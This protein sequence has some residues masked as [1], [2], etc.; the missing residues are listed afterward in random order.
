M[1][2]YLEFVTPEL[3]R[4]SLAPILADIRSSMLEEVDFSKEA[5][6]LTSFGEFLDRKGLRGVAT[7]PFVFRQFSS[8]R[9]EGMAYFLT[10]KDRQPVLKV[11]ASARNTM[12]LKR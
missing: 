10:Y 7:C 3:T 9:W 5:H 8:K 6:H 12:V 4:L 11:V 2:R 1:S